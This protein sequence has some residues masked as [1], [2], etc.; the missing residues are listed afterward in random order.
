MLG[1]LDAD[2]IGLEV[3]ERG[4]GRVID[5]VSLT[6]PAGASPQ[7]VLGH[8]SR[9]EGIDVEGIRLAGSGRRTRPELLT[10]AADLIRSAPR[11]AG[12]EL[13][14]LVAEDLRSDWCAVVIDGEVLAS[15]GLI[16]S[17][18]WIVAFDAGAA[19]SPTELVVAEGVM[20]AHRGDVSVL[21]GRAEIG[22]LDSEGHE[23]LA[24]A[25]LGEAV[26]QVN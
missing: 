14:R 13:C 9:V 11:V 10:A 17:L 16:P 24:W 23:L 3:V 19:A 1:H 18:D 5:E 7:D 6:L 22:F 12:G 21:A 26:L 8:L 20:R 25:S 2:V 15:E 4:G